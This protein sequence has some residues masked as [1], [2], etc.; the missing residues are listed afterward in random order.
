[1]GVDWYYVTSFHVDEA[2]GFRLKDDDINSC[3][4]FLKSMKKQF[5]SFYG[6][7]TKFDYQVEEPYIYAEDS[8]FLFYNSNLKSGGI[9]LPGDYQMK[10]DNHYGNITYKTKEIQFEHLIPEN[11]ECLGYGEF[12]VCNT[13]QEAKTLGKKIKNDSKS[14]KVYGN[15]QYDKA[16]W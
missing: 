3:L 7:Y 1:M 9:N 5:K 12:Q 6:I 15:V 14:E 16:K 10:Y 8:F 2:I 4:R 11:L 13:L